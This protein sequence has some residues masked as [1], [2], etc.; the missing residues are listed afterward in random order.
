[1]HEILDIVDDE[2]AVETWL[3]ICSI[4]FWQFTGIARYLSSN[5]KKKKNFK[6]KKKEKGRLWIY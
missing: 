1:M 6:K 2:L 5:K 4:C 3:G